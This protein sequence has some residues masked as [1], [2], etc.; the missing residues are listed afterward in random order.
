MVG[1]GVGGSRK[2]RCHWDHDP[3]GANTHGPQVPALT[4]KDVERI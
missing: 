2:G 4:K 3:L 1:G